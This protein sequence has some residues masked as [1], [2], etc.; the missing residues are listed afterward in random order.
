M[1]RA[2]RRDQIPEDGK[3][4]TRATR[5]PRTA[6]VWEFVHSG[7]DAWEIIDKD[8]P[9]H[10]VY[11]SYSS[12]LRQNS[13]LAARVTVLERKDRIFLVRKERDNAEQNY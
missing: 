4:S 9:T 2:I 11:S 1:H 12:V 13:R 5:K 7:D 8:L 10:S 3:I 6:E